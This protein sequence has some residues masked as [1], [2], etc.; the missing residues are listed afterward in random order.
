[1]LLFYILLTQDLNQVDVIST[2]VLDSNSISKMHSV[3]ETKAALE[4]D[5]GGFRSNSEI[6]SEWEGRLLYFEKN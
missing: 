3:N 1:M 4:Y 2:Q 5:V 6:G